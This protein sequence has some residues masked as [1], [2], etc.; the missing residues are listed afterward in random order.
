MQMP[1]KLVD[2]TLPLPKYE[3]TGAAAFDLYA[4][5]SLTVPPFQPTIIPLNVVVKIPHGYFLMLSA[6]SSL[7]RKKGL[8]IANGIGVIDEDYCGD[9]DEIGLSVINFTQKPV[10]VEKGERLCQGILVKITLASLR[11]VSKMTNKSRGGF[12]TTG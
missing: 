11:Q 8:M 5:I 4:R 2:S 1:I 10:I 6:R 12:G 9:E 3:T 7:A